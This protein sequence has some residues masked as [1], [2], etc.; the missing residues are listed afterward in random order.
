MARRVV[1]RL[2]LQ[3]GQYLNTVSSWWK[4]RNWLK[5]LRWTCSRAQRPVLRF[6]TIQR[7]V[8]QTKKMGGTSAALAP[9]ESSA[10]ITDP[11][12]LCPNEKSAENS[13]VIDV[14]LHRP[15]KQSIVGL[16]ME[17]ATLQFHS[18]ILWRHRD[19]PPTTLCTSYDFFNWPVVIRLKT[20]FYALPPLN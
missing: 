10:F 4:K 20:L 16:M 6:V 13:F 15:I 8:L 18:E 1:N 7:A 9:N 11:L 14:T 19:P 12:S 2:K 5:I 3:F 17:V